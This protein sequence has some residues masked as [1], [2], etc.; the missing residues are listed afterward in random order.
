LRRNISRSL[1]GIILICAAVAV[2][3]NSLGW[4]IVD[5]FNG[6]WTLFLIIPGIAGLVSYGFNIGSACM[7]LIGAW[8]LAREQNWIS[9]PLA[10][11]MIWVVILML[12]GLKLIFGSFRG[13]KVPNSPVMFDGIKDANDSSNTVNYSAIFGSVEVSNNSLSLCGGSV[14]AIFGGAGLDLREAVPVDGAVIEANAIFG[15]VVIYAPKNCRIQINGIPFF[16]GCNCKAQRPNDAAL[17][18]ITIKYSCVFGGVEV[19]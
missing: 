14:S 8:L 13:N 19:K 12:I 5:D 6:W 7:V 18:L 15:G 4:W 1:F 2:F 9:S 17:P 11:S 16:G 3:G 10:N